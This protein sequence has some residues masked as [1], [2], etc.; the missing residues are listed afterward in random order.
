MVNSL[1]ERVYRVRR[2][3]EG[4]LELGMPR[5]A[6]QAIQRRT[7]LV[8]NDARGCYLLGECLREMR[9]YREAISPLSRSL[10]LIPDDIHV[11]MA[12]AWCYKRVGHVDQAIDSLEPA[13]DIEPGSAILHYNLACYWSLAHDRHQALRYLANALRIDGNFR[14]LVED[15]PDFDP[16]RSD[17]VFQDLTQ[18]LG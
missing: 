2:E 3:A 18:L 5:Q 16:L 10:E 1:R 9:R 7:P 4:Y 6:L 13:I 12:L 11:R 17:P 8:H 14:E 15:E